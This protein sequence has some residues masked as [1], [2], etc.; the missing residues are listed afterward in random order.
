M[1]RSAQMPDI[2]SQVEMRLH[3]V[4]GHTPVLIETLPTRFCALILDLIIKQAA[5]QQHQQHGV[6]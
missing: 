1:A 3:R 6:I 5:A 4:Q 2:S